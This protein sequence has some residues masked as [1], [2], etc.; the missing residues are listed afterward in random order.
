MD[1]RKRGRVGLLGIKRSAADA[2]HPPGRTAQILHPVQTATAEGAER[3][4]TV[5]LRVIFAGRPALHA[6]RLV[7]RSRKPRSG[8]GRPAAPCG[9]GPFADFGVRRLRRSAVAQ[10]PSRALRRSTARPRPSAGRAACN[11]GETQAPREA[12]SRRPG[13]ASSG[14]R[15]RRRRSSPAWPAGPDTPSCRRRTREGEHEGG[16]MSR[17]KSLDLPP[18]RHARLRGH[19]RF[20]FSLAARRPSRGYPACGRA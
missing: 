14:A 16:G 6:R 10:N 13:T 2:R 19:P 12:R 17:N 11:P 1:A 3:R 4:A 5:V 18:S 15:R 9:V 8:R 7:H 20:T